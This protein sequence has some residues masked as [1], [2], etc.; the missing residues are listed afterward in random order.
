MGSAGFLKMTT[1][2][3]FGQTAIRLLSPF[4]AWRVRLLSSRVSTTIKA[5]DRKRSAEPARRAVVVVVLR[6]VAR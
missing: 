6:H 1:E 3:S 5:S 2:V 4:H